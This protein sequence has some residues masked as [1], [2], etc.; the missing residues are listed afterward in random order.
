MAALFDGADLAGKTD[1]WMLEQDRELMDLLRQFS[2]N[3]VAKTKVFALLERHLHQ[4]LPKPP[5]PSPI[6]R[7]PFRCG[8]QRL[9]SPLGPPAPPAQAPRRRR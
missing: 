8:A 6:P 7:L 5:L 3:I 2:T 4:N 9:A 1:D